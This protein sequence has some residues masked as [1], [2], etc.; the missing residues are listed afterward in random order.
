MSNETDDI[1]KKI[2]P[3]YDTEGSEEYKEDFW[4]NMSEKETYD[5]NA[6]NLKTLGDPQYDYI[7]CWEPGRFDDDEQFTDFNSVFEVDYNWWKFQ[8]DASL[9]SIEEYRGDPKDEQ[10]EKYYEESIEQHTKRY[11]KYTIYLSGD[12]YRLFDGDTF[13]YSQLISARWYLYYEGEKLLDTLQEECIPFK[14]C[15]MDD[16]D[17]EMDESG[18]F[19]WL[20][21]SDPTKRYDAGGREV[22]L[23]KYLDVMRKYQQDTMLDKIDK[24]LI[25]YNIVFSG[26]TFRQDKG[27]EEED[28]DPFTDFI[29]FD[30]ASLK[31]VSPKHFLE[32]FSDHQIS[33]VEFQRIIDETKEM[34][35]KDQEKL[36]KENKEKYHKL[37]THL[38]QNL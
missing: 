13:L 23:D 35:R 10:R 17:D 37:I 2:R 30:V 27:Y 6:L 8:R 29:F 16:E 18:N 5:L 26:K 24:L 38:Y 12:W 11:N 20:N 31:H 33:F 36:Y 21:E 3:D 9:E 14:Y 7:T 32:T 19:K 34:V 22:E 25:K 28:F 4:A 15:R 1:I